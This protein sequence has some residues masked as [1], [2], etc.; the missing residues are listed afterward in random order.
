MDGYTK[1]NGDIGSNK[2]WSNAVNTLLSAME[3]ILLDEDLQPL[4]PREHH[5][6]DSKRKTHLQEVAATVPIH[7][8]Q[9]L[10]VL[11]DFI[12]SK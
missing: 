2:I 3:S 1:G 12:E 10:R 6:H 7:T 9:D 5:N 8:K 4:W 11:V